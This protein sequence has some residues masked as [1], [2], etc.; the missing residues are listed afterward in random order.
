M[1]WRSGACAGC[2][3]V[4]AVTAETTST[5]ALAVEAASAAA[6]TIPSR[7]TIENKTFSPSV[8]DTSTSHVLAPVTCDV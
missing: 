2:E 4:A 5:E 3:C 6:E 1:K 8:R 7:G